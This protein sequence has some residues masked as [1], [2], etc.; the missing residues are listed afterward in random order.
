VRKKVNETFNADSLEK[1]FGDAELFLAVFPND[2]N[3]KK[4]S[5]ELVV[6]T[7]KAVEDAIG[8][9]IRRSGSSLFTPF[10]VRLSA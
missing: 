9:F 7:F 2:E 5:V 10:A 6:A 1:S 8:F 3:I 4:A